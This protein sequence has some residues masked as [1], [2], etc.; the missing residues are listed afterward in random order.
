MNAGIWLR[1]QVGLVT[2]ELVMAQMLTSDISDR[3]ELGLSKS[4]PVCS[5]EQT[6]A[7][8]AATSR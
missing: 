8:R 6:P 7:G 4:S 1:R 3:E 2:P 5:A